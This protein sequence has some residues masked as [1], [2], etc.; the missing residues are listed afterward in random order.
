MFNL[1]NIG[2]IFTQIL[3]ANFNIMNNKTICFNMNSFK[4]LR[5]IQQLQEILMSC[6]V[7]DMKLTDFIVFGMY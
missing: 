6:Q 3:V 7:L 4:I 5:D 2:Y 1:F